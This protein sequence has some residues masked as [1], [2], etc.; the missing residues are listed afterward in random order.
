[1][2]PISKSFKGNRGGGNHDFRWNLFCLTVPKIVVEAP[3]CVSKIFRYRKF[4]WIRG[5]NWERWLELSRFSV[6]TVLSHSS[7]DFC[8]GTFMW[9]RSILVWK[10]YMYKR[11]VSRFSV[12]TVLSP[13]TQTLCRGTLL[14]FRL[15]PESNTFEDKRA[16][17][18]YPN[19]CH[20]CFVSQYQN[21]S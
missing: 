21:V 18:A 12:E 20:I 15:F 14:C 5:E 10:N 11:D 16:R 19:F 3:F 17:G 2:F 7:E 4:Y 9:L 13:S 8:R 6:E 1:M